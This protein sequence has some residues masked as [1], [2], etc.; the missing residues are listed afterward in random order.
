M[1]ENSIEFM[2]S[3]FVTLSNF[4]QKS[5]NLGK[6][7]SSINRTNRVLNQKKKTI[8][9]SNN[10]KEKTMKSKDRKQR[11]K[12]RFEEKKEQKLHWFS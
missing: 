1:V 2:G 5:K 3:S 7:S 8:I 10:P 9:I 11:T 12:R 6:K 4:L